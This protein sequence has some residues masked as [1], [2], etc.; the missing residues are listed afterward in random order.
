MHFNKYLWH[1]KE[2]QGHFQKEIES[3]VF[4]TAASAAASLGT[5]AAEAATAGVNLWVYF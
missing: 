2:A 5:E 4:H 1:H 3:S